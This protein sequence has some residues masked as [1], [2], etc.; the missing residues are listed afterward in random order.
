MK[1]LIS[2]LMAIML[3]VVLV[4]PMTQAAEPLKPFRIMLDGAM[5]FTGEAAKTLPEQDKALKPGDLGRFVLEMESYLE[6][7][8][9]ND[10]Y[11]L[12]VEDWG[13]AE[14][15]QQK[16]IAAFMAKDGPD[17]FVGETQQPGF[18]MQGYYE[19][20]PESL[21]SILKKDVV[22][23]SW[24]PMQTKGK[25]YGLAAQPGVN[26][27]YWNKD[28]LK[29]ARLDPEKGPK[30]WD[31]LLA[32][33]TTITKAGKGK[34]YGGGTYL[35]PNYGGS[36][37]YT[38]FPLMLGGGYA[39]EDGTPTF[40]S[41]ANIKAFE[42]LRLLAKQCPQ[43]IVVGPGEGPWW[44]ALNRKEVAITVDGPWRITEGSKMGLNIGVGSL[45][46]PK[47]GKPANVT[48]GAAFYAVHTF[49]KNKEEGFKF[50]QYLVSKDAQAVIAKWAIRAPV[51]KK[52][53]ED[54]SFKNGYPAM[55]TVYQTMK[56][57]VK[58]LPTF[59]KN[60]A[61]VWDVWNKAVSMIVITNDPVAKILKNAQKEALGLVK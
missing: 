43:G 26:S 15:L 36:L 34:F 12:V 4:I 47:G 51:L 54:P 27:L 56:E 53:A 9:N 61:K 18:A 35:G 8:L 46:L 5:F 23:A 31:E 10:G 55:Y 42:Y 22:S 44:D 24:G 49:S 2:I 3:M 17:L 16:Q 28:L 59:K 11:T 48:I 14:Q 7:Q 57:G 58:G 60:D 41:S 25:I 45:P 30:T 33:A 1:K 39:D 6:K 40:D 50:L 19:P 38:V 21:V 13:W 20:L 29:A 32:M 37:R 52:V